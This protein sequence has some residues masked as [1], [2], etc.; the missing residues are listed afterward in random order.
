M[1]FGVG[2]S[3]LE[4]FNPDYL[5]DKDSGFKSQKFVDEKVIPQLRDLV[6]RY[7]PELIWGNGYWEAPD[8]YWKSK[9][10][11]AWLYNSSPV[12]VRESL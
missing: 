3:Q 5:S 11:L 9:D 10:F 1:H 2:Y 6:I 12:K 4:W 7:K 8:T